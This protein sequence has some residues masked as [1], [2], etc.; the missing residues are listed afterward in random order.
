LKL[1]VTGLCLQGNKGGPAIA[2]S[3]KKQ[4]EQQIDRAEFIFSVPS[5]EEY[6]YE[7]V[8]AER[9]QVDIVEVFNAKDLI[10]PFCF[11]HQRYKRGLAW[12]RAL[13]KVDYV[14]DMSAISYVGPPIKPKAAFR[15]ELRFYY[16]LLARIFRK[17]FI[18][19]TQSY[20]PFS[21]PL[22]RFL[23]KLDL[24]KQQVV[25]C[26]GQ[27]SMEQVEAL[28]P[29]KKVRS[30][31]DVAISLEFDSKWADDY[32]AKLAGI[33]PSR[34]IT[35]SPSAVNYGKTGPAGENRHVK[36]IIQLCQ[37][38]LDQQYHI[39]L[40]PHT[41]RPGRHQPDNCDF[42]VCLLVKEN[43]AENAAVRVL[44]ED[45]SPIELKSLISQAQL[46]IGAR[47]HTIIAALSSGVPCVSLSWHHK[48]RDLMLM[49]GLEDFVYE[50]VESDAIDILLGQV[51]KMGSGLAG[52]RS[53]LKE[54]QTEMLKQ[55]EENTQM[56][57]EI[58][59]GI[60]S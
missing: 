7:K 34:L 12:I 27:D 54:K 14:I 31:P 47:Y 49:Y 4:L 38:L 32:L 37:H 36:T 15:Q 30:F 17:G 41:F 22:I 43:F 60:K 28:L 25:F 44:E 58:I 23:G 2:L 24:K 51:D 19:W 13:R 8:W 20:G 42:G 6:E 26:R 11:I 3:L 35:V 50:E 46:H 39:L 16:F 53:Q 33:D 40:L 48:Y 52:Y 57:A 5:S 21:T 45:L 56:A 59:R 1:L 10:P 29:G 18:A 9:Y 55:V